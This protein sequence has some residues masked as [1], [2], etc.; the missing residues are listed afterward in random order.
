MP[1]QSASFP[2]LLFVLPVDDIYIYI[3]ILYNSKDSTRRLTNDHLSPSV[4][5]SEK[6]DHDDEPVGGA[7]K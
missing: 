1:L 5:E 2:A 3:Y 4:S 7:G 6:S